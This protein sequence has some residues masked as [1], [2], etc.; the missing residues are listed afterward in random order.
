MMGFKNRFS[1]LAI[2][3]DVDVKF[4]SLIVRVINQIIPLKGATESYCLRGA[5]W[6]SL[7]S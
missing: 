6:G 7:E 4:T 1:R 3:I 2:G 5:L